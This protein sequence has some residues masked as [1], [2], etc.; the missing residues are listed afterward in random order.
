MKGLIQFILLLNVSVF[1]Q[2]PHEFFRQERPH[3][4]HIRDRKFIRNS[5]L[6][7]AWSPQNNLVPAV[8]SILSAGVNEDWVA[9]F[10]NPGYSYDYAQDIAVGASGN[11]Y[12]TGSRETIAGEFNFVTV[13]Y[14]SAGEEQWAV[15]LPNN[16]GSPVGIALDNFENVYVAGSRF[17]AVKY[18]SAGE[19]QWVGQYDDAPNGKP[20]FARALALLGNEIYVTGSIIAFSDSFSTAHEN[21]LTVKFDVRG[22]QVWATTYDGF[23]AREDKATAIAVTPNGVFVTGLSLDRRFSKSDFVTIGYNPGSGAQLWVAKRSGAD[24]FLFGE[25]AIAAEGVYVYVTGYQSIIIKYNALTGEEL[26]VR[27]GCCRN[28]RAITLDAAGNVYIT[29]EDFVTRKF[30]SDGEEQWSTNINRDGDAYDIVAFDSF[31]YVTGRGRD[32]GSNKDYDYVTI[33][34]QRDTGQELWVARYDGL[35]QD[36]G[37]DVGLGIAV[38]SGNVNRGAVYV[39]GA[40]E[41]TLGDFD[42]AT[43]RYGGNGTQVWAARHNEPGN[44]VDLVRAAVVDADGNVY[45]T[46]LSRIIGRGSDYLTVKYNSAGARQWSATYNSGLGTG[47][48]IANGI[49]V[50]VS[51]NVYVTGLSAGAGDKRHVDA[52]TIK[53]TGDGSELWVVRF[54]GQDH[55]DDAGNAIVVDDAGNVYVTGYSFGTTTK[56]NYLTI[57]YD[58]FGQQQWL[59]NYNYSPFGL[60]DL[61]DEAA[62]LTVDGLGNVYVTGKSTSQSTS[63]DYATVK[64]NAFG[65]QQWAARYDFSL[66]GGDAFIT[67]ERAVAIAIDGG[68]N[69]YVTGESEARHFDRNF[70][71]ATIKYNAFGVQLWASRYDASIFVDNPLDP[72]ASI[73]TDDRSADLAVDASGNVYVTGISGDKDDVGNAFE[74]NYDY[75]TIKY[76][77][78]GTQQW[79][80]KYNSPNNGADFANAIVLDDD[81]NIYV[82][83]GSFNHAV[84]EVFAEDIVGVYDYATVKYNCA[85]AQQ[86]VVRYNDPLN[87][88]D[89]AVGIGL[90][91][92]GHVYVAGSSD[93]LLT[94][95]GDRINELSI[96]S[97]YVAIRYSQ[98]QQSTNKCPIVV[99]PLPRVVLNAGGSPYVRDLNKAP[100]VFSD[101]ENDPLTYSTSGSDSSVAVGSI[102]GNVLKVAPVDSGLTTIFITAADG[103]GGMALDTLV[104]SVIGHVTSVE[105]GSETQLIKEYKLYQ[106]YP[107]PFNPETVIGYDIPQAGEVTLKVYNVV[108]QEMRTLV[109][110]FQPAG[111]YKTTWDGR[112]H[113]GVVV[114]SGIYFY[115]LEA[116]SFIK[117]RKMSLLR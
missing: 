7:K 21:F 111:S 114:P 108:G 106:S 116:T 61:D 26:W 23:Q 14:N 102:T 50:D 43:I 72:D 30:N 10:D 35:G 70:D 32:L 64:Y 48:N 94:Y 45:V 5:S 79:V 105:N 2:S 1:A 109:K 91:G 20:R 112:D 33:Q 117:T 9:R 113:H 63:E 83:G 18:N 42:Y 34:Y 99:F 107:N 115:R 103:R 54:D 53:Y 46:G 92:S 71:F 80:T 55:G 84:E 36:D 49:A 65:V 66:L 62:D 38:N 57:K 13:K 41:G 15:R 82:T 8:S 95:L 44:S 56:Q 28:A 11:V 16:S 69:V 78:F 85:G 77:P 52:V 24:S 74:T 19:Q 89:V 51:G 59:A 47:L 17:L 87:G 60:G 40:S 6:P 27:G 25:N 31:I 98:D 104:V 86:W 58:T 22:R 93:S 73:I 76:N 81:C 97:D 29:G 96:Y 4:V 101:P 68:G 75:T 100:A 67:K 37:D 3:E 39:T 12:V 110:K 90:D 88:D